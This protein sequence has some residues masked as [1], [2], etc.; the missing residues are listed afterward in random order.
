MA[1]FLCATA[2]FGSI[3]IQIVG[4][5]QIDMK[6]ETQADKGKLLAIN[7]A[8]PCLI[9]SVFFYISGI[10]YGRVK[11]EMEIQKEDAMTK[12]SQFQFT[13][14]DKESVQSYGQFQ[15]NEVEK[16]Y[17]FEKGVGFSFQ[18]QVSSSVQPVSRGL[19][20]SSHV[21]NRPIQ[22]GLGNT[23]DTVTDGTRVIITEDAEQPLIGSNES[24]KHSVNSSQKN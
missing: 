7:T 23:Q 4:Q 14:D 12:A 13:K 10:Y 6:I 22:T 5:I 2:M 15:Y 9:A 24:N 19:G 21:K 20:K 16:V 3:G 8:L 11:R 1:V 18:R 17:R